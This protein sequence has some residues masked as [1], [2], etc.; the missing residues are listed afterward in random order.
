VTRGN[1]SEEHP[2]ILLITG[3]AFVVL[4][5]SL[6]FLID[7]WVPTGSRQ[8]PGWFIIAMSLTIGIFLVAMGVSGLRR[9][10]R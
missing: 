1:D 6:V 10:H 4:G 8:I 2:G 3:A 7:P 9:P 5:G